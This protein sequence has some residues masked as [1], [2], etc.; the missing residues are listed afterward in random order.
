VVHH[1]PV[2]V[3]QEY[4]MDLVLIAIIDG[5]R[6][7]VSLVEVHHW[8]VKH[9]GIPRDSFQVR[10]YF[11]EDFTIVFSFLNNMLRVLHDPPTRNSSLS[12]IF[13]RWH[14][15]LHTK[16]EVHLYRITVRIWRM[17]AHVCNLSTAS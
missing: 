10:R 16:V 9:F 17:L 14:W 1:S 2:I 8:I 12:F 5:T 13:K 6:P 7:P 15:N 3:D 11:L 4:V